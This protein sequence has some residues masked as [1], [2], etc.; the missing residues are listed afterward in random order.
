M[1]SR[2]LN[3][4]CTGT[5]YV[6]KSLASFTGL[7]QFFMLRPSSARS[8][9]CFCSVIG[10]SLLS[11]C[12]HLLNFVLYKCRKKRKWDQPAAEAL[13]SS[14]MSMPLPGM[15]PFGGANPLT[16]FGMPNMM[17]MMGGYMGLPY[18][19]TNMSVASPLTPNNSAAAIV[20]KINQV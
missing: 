16:A 10:F 20:Q 14:A 15:M 9:Y 8:L 5:C 18:V 13:V 4:H 1:Q 7:Y 12:G 19:Q 6:V 3:L 2:F 11:I 17:T